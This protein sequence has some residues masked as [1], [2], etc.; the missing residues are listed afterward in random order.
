MKHLRMCIVATSLENMSAKRQE[1][2]MLVLRSLYLV[3]P[4]FAEAAE[5]ARNGLDGWWHNASHGLVWTADIG[6]SAHQRC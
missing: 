2:L 5:S 6:L 1:V 3:M 4:Y